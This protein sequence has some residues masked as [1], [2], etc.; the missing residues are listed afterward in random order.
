[1]RIGNQPYVRTIGM[2][3]GWHGYRAYGASGG[4]NADW[5]G[6]DAY[7]YRQRNCPLQGALRVECFKDSYGTRIGINRPKSPNKAPF[8]GNAHS[9]AYGLN[10]PPTSNSI[11]WPEIRADGF[12]RQAGGALPFDDGTQSRQ[13]VTNGDFILKLLVPSL[14]CLTS[15]PMTSTRL[16]NNRFSVTFF[17][18]RAPIGALFGNRS[19]RFARNSLARYRVV[20]SLATNS[21]RPCA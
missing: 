19:H 18:D 7:F 8:I 21:C 10:F 3:I 5:W 17:G 11:L 20:A 1:M 6:V 16:K 14:V 12:D 2:G 15:K 9:A 4:G 13:L